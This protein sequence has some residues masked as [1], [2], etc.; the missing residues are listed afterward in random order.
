MLQVVVFSDEDVFTQAPSA[1]TDQ[2][3]AHKCVEPAPLE[4]HFTHL[5]CLFIEYI[6]LSVRHALPPLSLHPFDLVLK[7]LFSVLPLLDLS[8]LLIKRLV[9]LRDVSLR[10]VHIGLVEGL[11]LKY[12]L[13]ELEVELID[14]L[15]L[16]VLLVEPLP[17]LVNQ[18][19]H[20]SK[21]EFTNSIYQ[22]VPYFQH[23]N[24][25]KHV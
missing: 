18:L 8:D 23:K 12:L 21:F 6:L 3:M 1:C 15:K 24:K 2:D 11:E 4:M 25:G 16:A 9:Q 5:Y 20:L 13:F 14:M 17:V 10:A 19:R 7:H 22:N